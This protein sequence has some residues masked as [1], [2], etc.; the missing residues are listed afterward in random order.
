MLMQTQVSRKGHISAAVYLLFGVTV[1]VVVVYSI[2]ADSTRA[3][4]AVLLLIIGM[5][6]ARGLIEA[7]QPSNPRWRRILSGSAA[8]C[9]GVALV[10]FVMSW[11]L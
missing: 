8:A 2:S 3:R 11:V 9:G 4:D 1:C 10:A 5:T 7:A 6:L